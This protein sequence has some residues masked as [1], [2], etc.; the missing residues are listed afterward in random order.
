MVKKLYSSP[1]CKTENL[2]K[3]HASAHL[4]LRKNRI[5]E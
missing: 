5:F 3:E 4:N 2:K 1:D